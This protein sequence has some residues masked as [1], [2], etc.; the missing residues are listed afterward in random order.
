[1]DQETIKAALNINF[2][3]ESENGKPI[4]VVKMVEYSLTIY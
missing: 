2:E 4:S 3:P 1:L